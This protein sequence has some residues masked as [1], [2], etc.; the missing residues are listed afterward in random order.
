M[1]EEHPK[2]VN[3]INYKFIETLDKKGKKIT[4]NIPFILSFRLFWS[5]YNDS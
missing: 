1:E 5:V 3:R 4:K 2:R